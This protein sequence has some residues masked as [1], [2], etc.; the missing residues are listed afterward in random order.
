MPK[1]ISDLSVDELGGPGS[2]LVRQR[3][4]HVELDRLLRGIEAAEGVEQN[5]LL[6]AL[7]RLVF[8]HAFAEEAV[9]WPIIRKHVPEGEK[10]TLDIEQ[11]HQ[12]IDELFSDLEA[13]PPQDPD[14]EPLL[15]RIFQLLR[16][17]VRDE[18]DQLLPMLRAAMTDRQL[19]R[20]GMM[21]S[22]VRRAAPTRP[23]PVV[24][25]R[26]PGNVVAAAPLTV[27]D[28]ARDRLDRLSDHAS[29]IVARPSH[30]GSRG[31]AAVAG[32]IEHIPPL[33]RGEHP[34]TRTTRR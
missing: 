23:H 27:V 15:Q 2:V 29:P 22:I 28:R 5:D 30:I 21:W 16:Q 6:R 34:S 4:D 19:H 14:R 17:D 25:R 3:D 9:L 13:M 10:L 8:P 32:V 33:T 26:P 18:E 1:S 7:C 31:L 20:T 12:Q 11:E 24:A